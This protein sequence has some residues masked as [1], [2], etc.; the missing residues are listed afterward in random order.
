[1]KNKFCRSAPF[2][3]SQERAKLVRKFFNRVFESLNDLL[4]IFV[5][6]RGTDKI[7]LK[8]FFFSFYVTGVLAL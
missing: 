7:T 2:F 8:S 1:M 4:S 5:Y 3:F 6:S